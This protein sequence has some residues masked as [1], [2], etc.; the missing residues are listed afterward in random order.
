MRT[1]KEE[2]NYKKQTIIKIYSQLIIHHQDKSKVSQIIHTISKTYNLSRTSFYLSNLRKELIL[3]LS[4]LK[5]DQLICFKT[6]KV[7]KIRKQNCKAIKFKD[8]K[9]HQICCQISMASRKNIKVLSFKIVINKDIKI[10]HNK[11]A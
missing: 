3:Y 1:K 2:W 4:R 9:F 5:L 10:L 6:F 11:I 7:F 8:R